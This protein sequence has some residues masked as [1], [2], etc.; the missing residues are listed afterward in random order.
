VDDFNTDAGIFIFLISTK[1]GGVGLNITSANVVV[2][3]DSAWNPS[4]DQ[5][6]QGISGMA[7]DT[8]CARESLYVNLFVP[9]RCVRSRIPDWSTAR[10][11]GVP[12]ADRGVR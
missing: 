2:I 4:D 7:A 12:A 10:R 1:A 6:A 5:Q 3:Y 11:P 8:G 9:Y